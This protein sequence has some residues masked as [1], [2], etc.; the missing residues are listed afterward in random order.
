M[1]K[2][3]KESIA[4]IGEGITEF[5]YFNSLK[6]E[7]RQLKLFPSYP[8]HSS[9]LPDIQKEIDRA[10]ERGY[11]L[12]FCIIDMDTKQNPDDRNKYNHFKQKNEGTHRSKKNG[13]YKVFFIENERCTE[14][15]FLYYF[16][17]TSRQF[18]DQASLIKLLNKQCHY[19]KTEH[20]FRTHP[21]HQ[22]F[23]SSGGSLSQA[24]NNSERSDKERHNS[25]R[26]HT[27]SQMHHFFKTI[28]ITE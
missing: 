12:I 20:F 28:G 23:I 26:S 11:T 16:I 3:I 10:A 4:V 18:T 17:Y 25:G 8:K 14:L 1:T 22:H 2:E 7:F 21:L 6:D 13:T 9:S 27:Y 19:E 24:I 15:F 5:F